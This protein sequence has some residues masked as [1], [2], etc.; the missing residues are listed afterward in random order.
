M[1]EAMRLAERHLIGS[2]L[3][4]ADGDL[5]AAAAIL[6]IDPQALRAR[7]LQHGLGARGGAA[8][9]ATASSAAGLPGAHLLN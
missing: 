3:Q 8:P 7:M 5:N 9:A 2:T 1:R 6:A 4:T